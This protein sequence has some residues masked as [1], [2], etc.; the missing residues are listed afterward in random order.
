MAGN[1]TVSY[2][3]NAKFPLGETFQDSVVYYGSLTFSGA[4][5]T[6]GTGGLPAT[7]GKGLA[8]LGPYSDRTPVSVSFKSVGG[9]DYNYIASTGKLLIIAGGGSGTAAPVEVTDTTA[10]NAATPNINLD[11]VTFA[12]KFFKGTV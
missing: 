6:Y 11:T 12:A 1:A 9:Y 2:V 3:K 7:T 5:D 8:A 4:G 10:L